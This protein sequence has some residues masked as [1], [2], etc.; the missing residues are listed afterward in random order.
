MKKLTA[1]LLAL[2]M[3]LALAACNKTPDETKPS[4]TQPTQTQAPETQP[5]QSE[6]STTEPTSAS[7]EPEKDPFA[8]SE[9]VM[10]YA[11]YAAADDDDVIN[12]EAFVQAKQ[13]YNTQ[14]GSA[15]LYL[16]DPDGAYF[17][18]GLYCTPEQYEQMTEG[19]LVHVTGYK[20]SYKGLPEIAYR[21]S[22]V[23]VVG[24]E[25]WIA[26][27]TDLTEAFATGDPF[28][29]VGQKFSVTAAIAASTDGQAFLYDWNGSGSRGSDVYF[30]VTIGGKVFQFLVES[31]LCNEDTD[32]YKAAEALK[33][34]DVVD[35]EGFLYWYDGP[36]PHITSITVKGNL[37]AK[38][39]GVMTYAQYAAAEDDDAINIEAFVQAKQAYN[40]QY[41]S[42]SLYLVDT[43]GAYF[44]YG[45]YCTPEQYEQMTEGTLIHVTGYKTSY[46]GLPEIAYRGSVVEVIGGMSWIAPAA[47]L[48]EA[49]ATGDPFEYVGQKFTVKA[50]IA[51]SADGQ[52][53]LYDWNGSGSRGS[54]VYFNVTIGEKSFQ[55]LVESSLCN[56][57]TEVYKAAEALK[58]GDTVEI[59]GF[60]YW[61][62]GPNPHVTEIV[63]K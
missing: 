21:D 7:T 11:Q 14:Y 32:V 20:T 58:V 63:V 2:V 25:S 23:E 5:S 15:S 38:S 4:E 39:E 40:T 49:F 6:P 9:G 13:A 34:N 62:D 8:K 52:A 33:V 46:K 29:Y 31:S 12:I 10:T 37:E 30:N 27:A 16:A 1:L 42:A 55:F 47:D 24:G 48:T 19:T 28:E 22:V 54:D 36:N 45:L 43:N 53:F 44:G 61:Y 60:L 51:P 18:Y 50:T 3:V 26:P 59:E 56:E 41:G 17:G 57:D 35:I